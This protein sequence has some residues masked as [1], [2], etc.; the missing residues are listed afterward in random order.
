MSRRSPNRIAVACVLFFSVLTGRRATAEVRLPAL[1]SDNMVLRSGMKLPVWGWADAGEKVTVAI[2]GREASAVAD[3]GGK[4]RVSLDALDAGGPFEMTVAG[5]S[6]TT[7]RNVLAG[8]VWICSGQSNMDMTVSQSG[9]AEAGIAD[10]DRPQ[11]RSFRVDR[12]PSLEVRED[13]KGLWRVCSPKTVG[14]FSGVGYYFGREL[15][16][17]LHVPVGL[18][19]NSWGGTPARAFMSWAALESAPELKPIADGFRE[20]LAKNPDLAENFHEYYRR[21][22]EAVCAYT[23]AGRDWQA[24]RKKA[25]AEGKPPPPATKSKYPNHLLGH[26]NHPSV[27]YAGMVAPLMPFALTGVVWYQGESDTGRGYQY[28]TLLPTLIKCWRRGWGQGDLPFLIVQLPNYKAPRP[29]PGLSGWAEVREA[30]LMAL[31]LPNTGLAVTIDLG[32]AKDVHPKNKID[33]GKRLALC[34][35]GQVYGRQ[36]TSS[37]PL[38]KAMTVHGDKAELSFTHVGSGLVAKG[39]GKLKHF[40]IAG[41]DRKFVWADAEIAADRV[42][43]RSDKV[44][45]PV[46]VRYAWADNPEGCNLYNREGLPASPFRTDD[47]PGLTGPA[48]RPPSRD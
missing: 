45:A 23:Q 16:E 24:A 5:K 39:G 30:Q 2:C 40:A 14:S 11:I 22:F 10:A 46:A 42:I 4:W 37:G 13:V 43:A 38:F 33:V 20:T 19:Q 26:K 36:T 6:V 27:L 1:F 7:I 32:D 15:H 25:E 3:E 12:T 21:W 44:S 28:R 48:K 17:E 9:A 29:E 47:W 34:A 8:E 35:L 18:I 31:S 41:A